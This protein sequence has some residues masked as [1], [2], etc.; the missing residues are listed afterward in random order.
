M[1]VGTACLSTSFLIFDP[2]KVFLAYTFSHAVEYFVFVWAYQRKRF[3]KPQPGR[4]LM[5]RLSRH[6]AVFY[7]SFLV[8]VSGVYIVA[9]YWGVTIFPGEKRP[10]FGGIS[11]A[12]W[13]Y[14]WGIAQSMIH[15]YYDGFLWKMRSPE[16][17]ANI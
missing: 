14:F 7:W 10:K 16:T 17:R 9:K 1:G 13:I 15:F 3:S 5:E 6:P 4:S 11:A 12:Q 2:V 8:I